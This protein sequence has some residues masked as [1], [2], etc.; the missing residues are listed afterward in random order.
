VAINIKDPEADR[1][2]REAAARRNQPIT[3]LIKDA[4]RALEAEEARAKQ[5][6]HDRI[7][8]ATR[9]VQEA[10]AAEHG[11]DYDPWAFRRQL[12]DDW[13]LDNGLDHL[14][15]EPRRGVREEPE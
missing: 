9:R 11:P 14:V 8:E 4:V 3:D 13:A 10:Y 6:R 1:M 7:M 12:W 5:A 15:D 2:V